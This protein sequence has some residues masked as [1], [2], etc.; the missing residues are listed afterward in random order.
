MRRFVKFVLG[1][2]VMAGLSWSP[3]RA[4]VDLQAMAAR[5]KVHHAAVPRKVLAFYYPWYYNPQV[6]GGS[7]LGMSWQNVDEATKQI[8]NVAHFP[9]LGPYD[10]H[11]PKL[12]A[13]HCA[14]AKA[15]GIDGWIVS[16]WGKAS[17]TDR[18]MPLLLDAARRAGLEVTIYYETVPHQKKPASAAADL[19]DVLNRYGKH[20]AWLSVDKKPVV[21]VYGRTLGEIGLPGWLETISLVHDKY[22]GGARFLGDDMGQ[23]AARIFDGIHTYNPVGS[24]VAKS[25]DQARAWARQTYPAW[26]KTAD[27]QGRISTITVIPGYDDTKIRKPGLR[28]DRLGGR[29]YEVQ[30]EEAIA[31]DPHWVLITSW[32]EWYEGSEIEPSAEFG[33]AY[34][35]QTARCAAQFKAKGPRPARSASAGPAAAANPEFEQLAFS[36][37]VLPDAGSAAIWALVRLPVQPAMLSSGQVADLQAADARK[38]P[39][40]F[41]AGDEHYRQTAVRGADVDEGL[42]RYL[43]GG[44]LLA[45]FPSGPMPFHYNESGKPVARSGKLGLPLSV[46]GPA[47]GWERPPEGAKLHFVKLGNHLPRVPASIP[48]PSSGELRWRPFVRSELSPEDRVIPLIE[49][50][51]GQGNSYGDAVVYVEHRAS[52]PKGGRLLYVCCNLVESEHG[53]TLIEDLLVFVARQIGRNSAK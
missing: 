25:A 12:V 52:E 47:G 6:P 8:G 23:T 4:Q 34:L 41:Y 51:D 13:Q 37:A 42:L 44:G 15:S 45:V 38:Y 22:P 29:L 31:A 20:P 5:L 24:L 49:L 32:N 1:L 53:E 11:D 9:T 40:L 21:F 46:A 18:A 39:V 27:R 10:S 33:E 48:F 50:R 14:W 30:W 17:P 43:R 3:A 2:L 36:S 16:W 28:C 26:V 19:L 7:G 35:R